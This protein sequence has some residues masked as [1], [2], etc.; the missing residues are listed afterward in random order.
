VALA[1]FERSVLVVNY[2]DVAFQI[3][4]SSKAGIAQIT[5]MGSFMGMGLQ[6]SFQ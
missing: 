4:S 3:T 6:M 1:A 5:S 2:F